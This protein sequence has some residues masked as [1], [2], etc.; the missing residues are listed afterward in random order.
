MNPG[1]TPTKTAHL[2]NKPEDTTT[3]MAARVLITTDY[4]RPGD[5]VDNLL[6]EHGLEPVYSPSSGPR[7]PEER[8]SLFNGISGAIL[9]SE[10][11]TA[12]M[13]TSASSLKVL[14]RS[15][16]GYD[17]IDTGAARQHGIRV[18]N[19]PG[20]N[21]DAVAEMTIA[22]ML[23]AARNLPSVIQGV[24]DGAW[25]RGAGRELRGSTLGVIG[26]GPSGKAVARLGAALGMTVLVSTSHPDSTEPDVKFTDFQTVVSAAD[27]LTL[28]ARP[29]RTRTPLIDRA[30]LETMKPTAVLI[31]TARG[32]LI[33]EDALADALSTGQI[34]GAAL[35]VVQNEPMP[36][37]HKLRNADNVLVT[38]HLAGQTVEARERAGVAAAW[39]VIDVLEGREPAHPVA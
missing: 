5:T 34:A 35:D 29:D 16:V 39:A 4:L 6:K 19:T 36:A 13:L 25:P 9:A 7:T 15:G 24:K 32:S 26:Y 21:H 27:Y 37:S 14:A 30:V 22:L 28:H 23:M 12:D 1:T 20:V 18:C 11:V 31:N 3:V 8:R 10:P 33:D 17:S 2:P 38:S